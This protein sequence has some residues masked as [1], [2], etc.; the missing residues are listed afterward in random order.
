[1]QGDEREEEFVVVASHSVVHK[2]TK[3]KKIIKI[4][5]RLKKLTKSGRTYSRISVLSCSVWIEEAS[6]LG[7]CGTP[8]DSV[9]HR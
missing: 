1:M 6:A 9:E 8:Q 5:A 2:W 7:T 4:S 3:Q